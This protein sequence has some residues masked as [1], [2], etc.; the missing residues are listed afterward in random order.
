MRYFLAAFLFAFP[1]QAQ[2]CQQVGNVVHCDNGQT[3]HQL[4]NGDVVDDWGNSWV[5]EGDYIHHTPALDA[6]REQQFPERFDNQLPLLDLYEPE[7]WFE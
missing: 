4:Y 6:R 7:D 3:F 1:A 2:M 5:R